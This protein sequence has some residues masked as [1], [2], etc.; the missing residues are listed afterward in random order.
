MLLFQQHCQGLGEVQFTGK[1]A[2]GGKGLLPRL[3]LPQQEGNA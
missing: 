2:G 1:V 3:Y